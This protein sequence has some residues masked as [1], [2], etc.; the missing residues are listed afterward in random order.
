MPP[1][2]LISSGPLRG[3]PGRFREVLNGAGFELIDPAG[4]HALTSEELAE[5]LP[6]CDAVVAGGEA[7]TAELIA[8]CP[9]LRIIARTGVG[10]DAVDVEA[11]SAR[12]IVVTITPGANH[13]SV[14]EQAFALLLAVTR[15][16]AWNDRIVR[17]GG[18][19]RTPRRL[20]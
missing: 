5:F 6:R 1:T 3:K 10:Y 19:D 7:Y 13:D 20:V 16:I 14:A 9:R 12:G 2:V 17:R 8:A 4:D 11:A 15:R 18:W